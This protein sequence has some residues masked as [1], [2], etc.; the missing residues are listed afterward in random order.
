MLFMFLLKYRLNQTYPILAL[1]FDVSEKTVQRVFRKVAPVLEEKVFGRLFYTQ[2]PETI[3]KNVPEGFRKQFPECLFIGDGAPMDI[4]KPDTFVFQKLTYCTYKS[5]NC[6]LYVLCKYVVVDD[7][8]F[9]VSPSRS[10]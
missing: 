4:K 3:K 5:R 1:W 9:V 8:Y 6:F 10:L 2:D 7:L